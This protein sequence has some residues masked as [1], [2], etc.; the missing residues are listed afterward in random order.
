MGASQDRTAADGVR[1]WAAVSVLSPRLRSLAAAWLAV[2][3]FW[4]EDGELDAVS[5]YGER[6]CLSEGSMWEG[7]CASVREVRAATEGWVRRHVLA[8]R[9]AAKHVR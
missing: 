1:P 4:N 9:R 7:K 3:V 8:P 6:F 5:V 2:G